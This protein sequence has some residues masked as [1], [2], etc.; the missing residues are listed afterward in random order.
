MGPIG[1][2][3]GSCSFINRYQSLSLLLAR[4]F[5][6]NTSIALS[7]VRRSL[8]GHLYWDVCIPLHD[9]HEGLLHPWVFRHRLSSEL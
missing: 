6:V 2:L 9:Y 7:D 1:E 4:G 5:C 3:W 8:P